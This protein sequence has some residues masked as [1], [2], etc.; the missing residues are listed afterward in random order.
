MRTVPFHISSVYQ[1]SNSVRSESRLHLLTSSEARILG[2]MSEKQPDDGTA[3]VLPAHCG[4]RRYAVDPSGLLDT[5]TA[6]D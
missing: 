6:V 2:A 5:L 4:G 3:L 1:C